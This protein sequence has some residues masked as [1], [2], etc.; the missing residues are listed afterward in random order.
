MAPDLKEILA[1]LGIHVSLLIVDSHEQTNFI[2]QSSQ[3]ASETGLT[4]RKLATKKTRDSGSTKCKVRAYNVL[5]YILRNLWAILSSFRAFVGQIVPNFQNFCPS[6]FHTF[7]W[8][9]MILADFV[10]QIPTRSI[11]RVLISTFYR[12]ES[13]KNMPKQWTDKVVVMQ[14]LLAVSLIFIRMRVSSKLLS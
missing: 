5:I 13:A 8:A 7:S 11:Y 14:T 9:H 2:D 12:G 1:K 4:E 3:L 10:G 6:H